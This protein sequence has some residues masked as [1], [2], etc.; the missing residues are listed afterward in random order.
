[1][2]I[3]DRVGQDRGRA[4]QHDRW[5]QQDPRAADPFDAR[6]RLAR[7]L[8]E[9]VYDVL[10]VGGR[11]RLVERNADRRVVNV[12]KVDTGGLRAAADGI[13]AAGNTDAERIEV[14]RV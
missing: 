1:A 12:A 2:R 3:E 6:R 11:D 13:D 10:D 9:H 7:G 8:C 4:A 14:V 5:L